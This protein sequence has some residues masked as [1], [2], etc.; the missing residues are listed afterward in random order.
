MTWF[1]ANNLTLRT[2]DGR[3]L[4]KTLKFSISAGEVIHIQ[5]ANGTGK[6]T[7]IKSLMGL[8]Q[9]FSGKLARNLKSDKISYLPQLTNYE[10]FLPVNFRDLLSG[11][12][13]DFKKKLSNY[14]SPTE[15]W[16]NLTWNKASGGERQ[17]LLILKTLLLERPLLILD[18]PFNHLDKTGREQVKNWI[19][20]FLEVPGNTL[21]LIHHGEWEMKGHKIKTVDLEEDESA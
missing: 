15:N 5:G 18:E 11:I 19:E 17:K 9:K 14:F 10:F 6:T 3:K 21:I 16:L 2:H 12:E 13:K 20:T 8:H 7:L 4:S 1:E